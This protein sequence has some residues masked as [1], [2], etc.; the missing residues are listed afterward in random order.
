VTSCPASWSSAAA[1]ELSTPP[2]IATM[3]FAIAYVFLDARFYEQTLTTVVYSTK[4]GLTPPVY[5]KYSILSGS[6]AAA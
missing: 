6:Q 5:D 4:S 2:L 1:S 3:I